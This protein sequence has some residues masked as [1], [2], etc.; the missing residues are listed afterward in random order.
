MTD[1]TKPWNGALVRAW[2]EN[3]VTSA[4]LEQ[5]A[6]DKRGYTAQ[7]EYDAA[8]AEEWACK[9]LLK[10]GRVGEQAD[11]AAHLKQLIAQDD[12]PVTGIYDDLRFGRSVRANL[13]KIARMTTANDGFA[14]R[15]RYQA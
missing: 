9:A 4:R 7:D 6:A 15:L 8:A 10:A 3:R 2:L 5:A 1:V 11:F 13:R 12:Y 14:N